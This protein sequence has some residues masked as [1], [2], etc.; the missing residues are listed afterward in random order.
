MDEGLSARPL[1][2]PSPNGVRNT[3][4]VQFPG[5][6]LTTQVRRPTRPSEK[7]SP[8]STRTNVNPPIRKCGASE[9]MTPQVR[10]AQPRNREGFT[11]E[12]GLSFRHFRFGL[13]Y[14]SGL[15]T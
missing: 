12:M 4:L 11:F 10:L 8:T 13:T 14:R 5:K 7:L 15:F 9:R 1:K 2:K 6:P 3:S